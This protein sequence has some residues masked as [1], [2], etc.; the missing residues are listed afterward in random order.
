MYTVLATVAVFTGTVSANGVAVLE[1]SG[2]RSRLKDRLPFCNG[3]LLHENKSPLTK[4]P[5]NALRMTIQIFFVLICHGEIAK[6]D[7]YREEILRSSRITF[8]KIIA[9]LKELN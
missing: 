4:M 8:A 9:K 2:E 6:D 3:L 1:S 5:V 7:T